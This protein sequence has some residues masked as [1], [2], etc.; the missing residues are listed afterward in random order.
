MGRE[1]RTAYLPFAPGCFVLGLET[2]R[3]SGVCVCV[4]CGEMVSAP[5]GMG[6]SQGFGLSDTCSSDALAQRM[7][8]MLSTFQCDLSSIS[9]EIQTLQEQ[10][11]AMNL[12][13][14]NRQAVRSQLSQL[15]DE[16][17][18]PANMIRCGGLG[19]SRGWGREVSSGLPFHD[20]IPPPVPSW[21][22]R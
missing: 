16:L 4:C 2:G 12:R 11:V 14:K 22:R 13:L 9:S 5:V 15:V 1:V 19:Q 21:R 18:V 6:G 3:T 7:E 20:S 10:S 17:V 8:Q